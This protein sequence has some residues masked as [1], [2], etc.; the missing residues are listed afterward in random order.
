MELM[1][2]HYSKPIALAVICLLKKGF[3]GP[4]LKGADARMPGGNWK[5]DFIHHSQKM[6][7]AGDP[8]ASAISKEFNG[9]VMTSFPQL[10]NEEIDEIL[11]YCNN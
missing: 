2:K 9:A 10:T 5:Y 6:I 1:E 7:N 11:R 4:G 8:Y 3:V